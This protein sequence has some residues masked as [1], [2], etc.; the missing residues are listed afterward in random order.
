MNARSGL[1]AALLSLPLI[2]SA[3]NNPGAIP[4]DPLP[5]IQLATVVASEMRRACAARFPD[6]ADSIEAIY[7]GW[8]LSTVSIKVFV[9]GR[10]YTNPVHAAIVE[11][12]KQDF[13]KQA[14]DKS[15]MD[16]EN[17]PSLLTGLTRDIPA[18]QLAPFTR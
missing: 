3:Q 4:T 14:Q 10:E 15:R 1:A 8:P 9:N 13:A 5:M 12:F 18:A 17:F 11:R 7:R 6:L 16:C 2:A